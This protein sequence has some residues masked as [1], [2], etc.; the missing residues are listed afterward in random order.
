MSLDA[1]RAIARL[2]A[3]YADAVTR[4]AWDE[5]ATMF[6]PGCPVQLDLRSGPPIETTGPDGLIELVSSRMDRFDFFLLVPL[7][8]V[9]DVDAAGRG[10]TGRF[11]FR[12]I[13][14]ERA[15]E[16]WST[17]YGVYRDVYAGT[18]DGWR[19]ASRAYS[20]LART[21]DDGTSLDVFD[22]PG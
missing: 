7:N 12:E 2:L 3:R 13:R 8:S 14:R 16:R 17:T 6:L 10:A 5:V 22:L 11:W 15:G 1:E 20:T 19:F 21:T 9:A 4:R 18:D